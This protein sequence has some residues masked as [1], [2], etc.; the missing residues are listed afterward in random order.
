MILSQR[1]LNDDADRLLM[2][3]LAAP[4]P[5]DNLRRL[6]L[7][8]RLSSWALDDPDNARLWFDDRGALAGWAALQTP[9]WTLDYA[10][11]PDAEPTL[12]PETQL[13]YLT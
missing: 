3:D 6:D 11:R 13:T 12:H 2:A 9:F 1:S 10:L 4:Y 7:P 8:Y 5:A